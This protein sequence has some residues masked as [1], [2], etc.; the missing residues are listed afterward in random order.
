MFSSDTSGDDDGVDIGDVTDP[1][2]NG[3]TEQPRD[4]TK[5]AK[6]SGEI[7]SN[8][9]TKGAKSASGLSIAEKDQSG[10]SSGSNS[11]VVAKTEDASSSS[12]PS[13]MLS[14]KAKEKVGSDQRLRLGSSSASPGS[15]SGKKNRFCPQLPCDAL[16]NGVITVGPKNC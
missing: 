7:I 9:T 14:G 16:G 10:S 13:K 5:S 12:K 4:R 1:L 2:S 15:A 8:G 6:S 11:A 3:S